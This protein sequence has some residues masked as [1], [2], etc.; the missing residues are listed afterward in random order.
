MKSTGILFLLLL[1]ITE[2]Y[3]EHKNNQYDFSTKNI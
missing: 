3:D 1:H 2:R